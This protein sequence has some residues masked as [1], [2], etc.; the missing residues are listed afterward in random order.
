MILEI[1]K[2]L[3]LDD[4]VNAFSANILPI[5]CKYK[6]RVRL[7]EPDDAL[8]QMA[9]ENLNPEQIASV[10]LNAFSFGSEM[11]LYTSFN[12]PGIS[13]LISRNLQHIQKISIYQAC[14]PNLTC[15][16]LCYNDVIGS[17]EL[18]NVFDCLNKPIKRFEIHC[19]GLTDQERL[20]GRV[21]LIGTRYFGSAFNTS[22][23]KRLTVEYFVL[24]TTHVS[25][26]SQNERFQQNGLHFLMTITD[27]IKRMNNIQY[28]RIIINECN[29]EQLLIVYRWKNLAYTCPQLKKVTLQVL[30]CIV[31]NKHVTEE[32][33]KIQKE[34]H[35]VRQT[36]KF[37]IILT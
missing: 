1:V 32:V 4:I 2:Y 23:T 9:L 20:I 26:S 35:N 37:Q 27:F 18:Q 13:L 17:I 5:L 10:R 36:I 33:L 12:D 22:N 29:L 19:G 14:F 6:T 11:R 7:S 3:T 34:L 28:V 15:L 24:D 16:S 30:E 31:Q 8:I 21:G 25:L